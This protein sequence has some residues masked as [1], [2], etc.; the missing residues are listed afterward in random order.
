[1]T[2]GGQ[3]A[4]LGRDGPS[5]AGA[6]AADSGGLRAGAFARAC[7]DHVPLLVGGTLAAALFAVLAAVYDRGSVLRADIRLEAWR[8]DLPA[9]VG[10]VGH[11][12]DW[13][14]GHWFLPPLV[15]AA[16]ALLVA[17]RR[18]GDALF[19]VAASGG[20]DLFLHTVKLATD[21]ERPHE[22]GDLPLGAAFP[23]GHATTALTIYVAL[24]LL[25]PGVAAGARRRLVAGAVCLAVLVGTGRFVYG[26]KTPSDV[27]AGLLLGVVWLAVLVIGRSA[28]GRREQR[29]RL[30]ADGS[31]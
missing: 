26:L 30:P 7:G 18:L 14:G 25:V 9:W 5:A 1:M 19:L 12:F 23:S 6:R 2:E 24:A 13:L 28:L 31:L 27:A 21:R 8:R 11:A 17:A 10:D 15:V 29:P 4:P 3:P 20:T 16:F 22:G